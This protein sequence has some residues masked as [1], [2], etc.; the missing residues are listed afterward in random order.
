M[1]FGY[2][3]EFGAG[4]TLNMVYDIMFTMIYFHKHVYSNIPIRFIHEG[5]NYEA[6]Y[7]PDGKE[8]RKGIFKQRNTE[9]V[10]DEAGVYMPN[11]MWNK[12]PEQVLMQFHEQRH[13]GCNVYYTT[14]VNKHAVKRLRDLSFIV[15][16]CYLRRILPLHFHFFFRGRYISVDPVWNKLYVIKR[17]KPAYFEGS[18]ESKKKYERYYRGSRIL[19]PSDAKRVF[20]AYKTDF[21]ISDN[22]M[23]GG[24]RPDTDESGNVVQTEKKIDILIAKH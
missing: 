6:Q 18:M 23:L 4:K 22:A 12:V 14:Q 3:G 15:N 11:F 19:Y 16:Y 7:V 8:F 20:E 10:I 5:K 24:K 9:I 21:I 17:F 2:V 1:I 13:T